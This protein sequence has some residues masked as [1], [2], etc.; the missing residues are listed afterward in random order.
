MAQAK[1]TGTGRVNRK[2]TVMAQPPK[3]ELSEEAKRMIA[4]A[5]ER[6][7]SAAKVKLNSQ[8]GRK[9]E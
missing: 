2:E 8:I 4:E 6:V 1:N 7:S 5:K 9:Q 3:I